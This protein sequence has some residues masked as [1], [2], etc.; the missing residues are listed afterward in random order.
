VDI[1]TAALGDSG[2]L[3]AASARDAEGVVLA[4]FGAGH[5]SPSLLRELRAAEVPVLVT[6]RV[7]RS[8]VLFETY[9]FEGAERDLRSSA[10]ICVPFLSPAAARIALL[11]CLGCGLD[12]AQISAALACFD[13]A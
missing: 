2:S 1:V 7:E 13:A 9:G 8:S 12:R 3:L 10:A 4:A 11:C 5:L 6:T